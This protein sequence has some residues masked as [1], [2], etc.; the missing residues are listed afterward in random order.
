MLPL[1]ALHLE[2]DTLYTLHSLDGAHHSTL[3]MQ[4]KTLPLVFGDGDKGQPR[5][6]GGELCTLGSET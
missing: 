5:L 4:G 6:P 2:H 1:T 3:F